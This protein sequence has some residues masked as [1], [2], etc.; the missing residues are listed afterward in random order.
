MGVGSSSCK[1]EPGRAV[2]IDAS[3]GDRSSENDSVA[4]RL[5][6]HIVGDPSR[7]VADWAKLE[8]DEISIRYSQAGP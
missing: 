2:L 1:S 6:S 4:E 8:T 5:P 3:L 7:N